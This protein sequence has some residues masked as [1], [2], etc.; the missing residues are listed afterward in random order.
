[1]NTRD[2]MHAAD[3]AAAI[4]HLVTS[5]RQIQLINIASGLESSIG[6]ISRLIADEYSLI[7]LEF[8][9]SEP[10]GIFNRSIDNSLLLSTGFKCSIDLGYG[11]PSLC[12][13]YASNVTRVRR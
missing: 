10:S 5:H 7:G 12:R 4:I 9:E 8:L 11:I 3:A 2:F 1:M 13:W 6:Y